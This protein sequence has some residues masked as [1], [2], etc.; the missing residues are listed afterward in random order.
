MP[1]QETLAFI[2]GGNM[3]SSLISGLVDNGY[4]AENIRVADPSETRRQFLKERIP[5]IILTGDN[6]VAA[7][8]AECIILAVKPQIMEQAIL[9]LGN[10]DGHPLF[11]SIAAGL[12]SSRISQ[13]LGDDCALV[14]AMP[15]TPALIGC[16][17]TGA[18][19]NGKVS[20]VQHSM[21]ESILRTAGELFWFENESDLNTVT[22]LSGSGP[23]YFFLL[24][25]AL[26]EG[27][28]SLGLS[29]TI[30]RSL[31][32][33]TAYGAAR[34]ALES[35]KSPAE[36]RIQVT[37]PGGTTEQALRIFEDGKF[38]ELVSEA[39]EAATKR[40][41]ELAEG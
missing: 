1:K 20:R 8:Q 24:I 18:Y 4:S 33:Q 40:A 5:G 7:D 15:N 13:W 12:T 3:A 25:E 22:A 16:G 36:L 39:M 34:L 17:V 29:P 30:S 31:A 21:A 27:G 2:G 41:S 23:A 14:R 38:R 10:T 6:S 35:D 28:I 11:I 32:I 9:G 37:S 26:E 19:A